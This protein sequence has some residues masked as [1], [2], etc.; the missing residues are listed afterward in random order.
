MIK[1]NER[2]IK[3]AGTSATIKIDVGDRLFAVN[4]MT[5]EISCPIKQGVPKPRISWRHNNAVIISNSVYAQVKENNDLLIPKLNAALQG[6][7]TCVAENIEGKDEASTS[8]FIRCK[9]VL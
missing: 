9:L 4:D 5:V 2:E 7:Y 1:K 6:L 3:A 8:I